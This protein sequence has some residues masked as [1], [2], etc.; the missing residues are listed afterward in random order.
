MEIK[1]LQPATTQ[2]PLNEYNLPVPK[3]DM[4]FRMGAT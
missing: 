3:I 2:L 4:N 1:N